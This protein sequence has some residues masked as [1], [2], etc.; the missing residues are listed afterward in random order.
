MAD[1]STKIATLQ[2]VLDTGA[3]TMTVDGITVAVDHASI[4][5]RIAALR[6]ADPT[7]NHARPRASKINLGGF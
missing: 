5:K 1:N 2:A 6:E 7:L 4:R 3:T